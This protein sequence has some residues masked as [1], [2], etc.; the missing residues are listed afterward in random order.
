M[1]NEVSEVQ[2]RAAAFSHARF[3][4]QVHGTIPAA[5]LMEGFE[6]AGQRVPFVNP[7]RGIFKPRTM[8]HLLSIRTVYPKPGG[9]VW[10]DDQREI[11]RRIFGAN[12]TFSY[13]FM[14]DNPEAAE[15]RWMRDAML[16]QIP[17]IYFLGVAPGRYQAI[18]P[19]YIVGWDAPTLRAEIAFGLVEEGPAVLDRG[20]ANKGLAQ[21]PTEYE[22]GLPAPEERRYALRTI[23]QRL[24]QAY[25]REA[26]LAA[27]R[28]RC[29]FSGLPEPL[30]LDAAHIVED[31]DERWGQP[32]I[33]N[34]LPLSKVH[35]AA[36]DAHLIGVDPD[37]RI[38][39]SERL[40]HQHD[41][42]I[43]R[44]LQQLNGSKIN[45]PRRT[46]D[47]PSRERLDLRFAQFR[48]AA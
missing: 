12:E 5:K 7:Q 30:L 32:A 44:A 45:W 15:N 4:M 16:S 47:A 42:D 31:R 19:T 10:Y 9:K 1:A 2:A 41:G 14:G 20:R 39:I 33:P 37:Y 18:V 21:Q 26:V 40:L 36:F 13:D 24:H 29:A 43:L 3:L 23:K 35:H 46:Q 48:S 38:H 25:F 34:G 11:H 6:V 27:Y 8:L 22:V 28:G 17:V